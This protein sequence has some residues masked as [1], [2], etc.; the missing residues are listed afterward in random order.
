MGNWLMTSQEY[1]GGKTASSINSV[2]KTRQLHAKTIKLYYYFLTPYTKINSKWIEGLNLTPETIKLL[3][4]NISSTFFDISFSNIFFYL[5][6]QAREMSKNK[7][8]WL[9]QAK[10]LLYSTRTTKKG[11]LLNGRRYFQTI[12]PT[13]V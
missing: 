1:R 8:M 10:K 12:Y 3:E 2:G 7:Q 11:C 13:R 4:K 5:P 9:H 6:C